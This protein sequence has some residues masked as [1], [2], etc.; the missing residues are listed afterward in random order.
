M[1]VV[2]ENDRVQAALAAHLE[3]LELGGP[4][5]DVSHLAGAERDELRELISLLDTTEGLALH[6]EEKVRAQETSA[7]RAGGRLLATL[8]DVLP[9]ATRVVNDPAATTTG[10]DGMDV[11]EGWIV[12]T[13]GGRV[14]VWLLTGDGALERSDQWLRDLERVFR[15]FPDTV[16]LALVE[17]DLSCLLVLPEDCAPTIEVPHGSLVG[18]RYRRP[19]HPV[20]EAL[21]VFLRELIPS[22]EPMQEITDQAGRLVDVEP[23]ATER[24]EVA[25]DEQIAAGNRARK[26]N[27]KRKALTELGPHHAT[28]LSKLVMQVHEG[29]TAPDDVEA[30]LRR[31]AGGPRPVANRETQR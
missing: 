22:W 3:H 9:A 23:I 17:P 25:I 24:A 13:F 1:G 15:L 30:E 12:G 21:S 27:P 7:T 16:G 11:V 5:P 18:R 26:T 20:D 10:I 8:R 14:R 29:R 4:E 6:G 31:L 28:G 2:T 19:V